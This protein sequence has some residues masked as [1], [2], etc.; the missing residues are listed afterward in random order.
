MNTPKIT[1]IIPIYNTFVFLERCLRSIKTQ[2]FK[3]FEVLLINDGSTDSSESFCEDFIKNDKRFILKNKMN[4]G[5]SSARNYGLKYALGDYISFV[6]SDDY[7][8]ENYCKIL[9]NIASS[10]NLDVLN[11]GLTYVKEG[12]KE[13]RFSVLPK[14]RLIPKLELIELIKF[15]STNKMLWFAWSNFYKREFLIENNIMFNE[16]VLLGE[17]SL[18]N[19][20]CFYNSIQLQNLYIIMFIMNRHL[21]KLNIKRTYYKRLKHN[22]MQEKSFI[23]SIKK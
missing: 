19:L 8:D 18:F 20:E 1:L 13:N 16:N 4:G 22:L 10:K 6:D 23:V 21:L 2:N 3:D 12:T 14:N 11:F 9:Y 7:I 5:L 17:D 15:A